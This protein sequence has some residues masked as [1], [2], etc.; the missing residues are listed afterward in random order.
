MAEQLFLKVFSRL[1]I[2][3]VLGATMQQHIPLF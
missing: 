1:T 2:Y 3:A